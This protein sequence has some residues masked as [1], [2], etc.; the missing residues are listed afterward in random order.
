M[1]S[2]ECIRKF[3]NKFEYNFIK[4]GN[5]QQTL[6]WKA[7]DAQT[8]PLKIMEKDSWDRFERFSEAIKDSHI[9]CFSITTYGM[10]CG[11]VSSTVYIGINMNH[12]LEEEN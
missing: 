9:V 5:M 10:A 1:I 8:N 12:C 11:Q 7:L 3:E 4:K 2:A 6:P